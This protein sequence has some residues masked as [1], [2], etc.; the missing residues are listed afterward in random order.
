M[1]HELKNSLLR[2]IAEEKFH[3]AF[4]C[5]GCR[6]NRQ[7]KVIHAACLTVAFDYCARCL[8]SHPPFGEFHGQGTHK[9]KYATIHT[10]MF[11]KGFKIP[12]EKDEISPGIGYPVGIGICI[13]RIT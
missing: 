9:I 5:P 1:T 6:K 10:V 11:P 7:W 13:Q 4:S 3:A 8:K 2:A 12:A